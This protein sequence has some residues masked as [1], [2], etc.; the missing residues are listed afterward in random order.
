M[1]SGM[2]TKERPPG[3]TEAAADLFAVAAARRAVRDRPWPIWLYAANTLLLGAMATTPLLPD[4]AALAAW[5]VSG[6]GVFAL[7]FWA[8]HR[9]GTPFAIPTSRG[10]GAAVAVSALFLAAALVVG[11]A[12]GAQWVVLACAAG[13]ALSYAAGSLIHYRSTHG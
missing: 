1:L 7:N 2:E 5:M 8:G 3:P 6:I 11:D 10:F 13:T 4:R 9:I 12:N